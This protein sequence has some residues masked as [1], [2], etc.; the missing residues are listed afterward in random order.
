[1]TK[2]FMALGTALLTIPIVVGTPFPAAATGSASAEVSDGH[3]YFQGTAERDS[4]YVRASDASAT[5]WRVT[6]FVDGG[7]AAGAGCSTNDQYSVICA[8]PVS[9]IVADLGG[10]RDFMTDDTYVYPPTLPQIVYA[11]PGDDFLF[12][13]ESGDLLY[14]Q[15]GD[16]EFVTRDS[17][18]PDVFRGGLG[19]D[20]LT[21]R[22]SPGPGGVTVT[23]DGV[24]DDGHAGEGDNVGADIE[25]IH[26]TNYD[27]VLSI[28][29]G[30][31]Y[32]LEGDDHVSLTSGSG[33]IFGGAN[34]D[35]LDAGPR[36]TLLFGGH[37]PD[38]LESSN[39]V[40]NVDDCDGA[41][42]IANVDPLDTTVG[43][44]TV[45]NT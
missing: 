26:G 36:R 30:D 2:L 29:K 10:G 45:N 4:V 33:R 6:D 8:G 19:R 37:G 32:G 5:S 17:T 35:T 41:K 40:P 12:G 25:L 39:G 15:A 27:D 13:S 24:A 28:P 34:A 43:C 23:E 20:R 44:E 7:V 42:D 11:G 9:D 22:V 3:I 38:V 18:F 21:Y 16:D 14:G 31:L 1:V